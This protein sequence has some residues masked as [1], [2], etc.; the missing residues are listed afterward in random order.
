MKRLTRL[1]ITISTILFAVSSAAT[2]S[3]PCS[4]TDELGILSCSDMP[5]LSSY[6]WSD[7]HEPVE[8]IIIASYLWSD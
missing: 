2:A 6:L 3:L 7:N 5:T 1:T 8:E 4:S